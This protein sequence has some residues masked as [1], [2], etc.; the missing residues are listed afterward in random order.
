MK[1]LMSRLSEAV[2]ASSPEQRRFVFGA[3]VGLALISGSQANATLT[4]PITGILCDFFNLNRRPG[5]VF[6]AV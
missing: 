6:L 2:R 4:L 1:R 3:L 5:A